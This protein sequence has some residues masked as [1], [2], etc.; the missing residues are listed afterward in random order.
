[1]GFAQQIVGEANMDTTPHFEIGSYRP[2]YLWGGPGTVRMNRLK[3][4]GV[5]VDEP[6]HDEAHSPTGARRVLDEM[7]CNWVHLMYDWGFP[8]EVEA[9]DWAA[10]ARGAKAYHEG[11]S[12]VFAYIQS[13]NCVYDGSF[14]DRDWY[15]ADANGKKTTY[16]AYSGRYMACLAHP[17]WRQ[18]L[19]DLAKGAIE[20]GAD[21]IFLDNLFQG[22]QPL[23][24]LDTWLGTTGCHCALC[25]QAYREETGGAIPASIRP[26]D[27]EFVR[28]L[29][30]RA[31][32][33][34]QLVGEI[35]AYA[36]ELQPGTPLAANDFDPIVR[37]SY[38]LY[39]IDLEALA[40]V[41][42][43][44]M[45]ENFAL[46]DW[47]AEPRPRLANNALNVRT[48][49]AIIGDSAHLSVLSYDVGIGFDPVYPP[50]RY[51]QG[52]AEATA[53]GVTM[54]TKG[55][56]YHD[57]EQM[58]LLT[59][60][61][62]APVRAAIGAYHAWLKANRT[63]LTGGRCN[64]APVALLY[65]GEALWLD[66]H[67][68]APLYFGAG[69]ALTAEGIPWRVI[70]PGDSLAGVRVVLVFDEQGQA[71]TSEGL[72]WRMF[73]RDTVQNGVQVFLAFEEE[74]QKLPPAEV[75]VVF[76]PELA[77]WQPRRPSAIGQRAILRS[78]VTA[79]TH[80]GL[81]AYGSLKPARLAM[82]SLGLPKL[83]T[84]TPLYYVPAAEARR[85]LVDALPPNLYPRLESESPAL[86]EVWRDGDTL[87]VHLAN[88]AREP[89][90]VRV[91][92]GAPLSGRA[93][94]PDGED[95][96]RCEGAE[97]A[98]ALD[99]YT[100]LLLTDASRIS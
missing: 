80:L 5:A 33:V 98:V 61:V 42:D 35:A 86:I 63:L 20:R 97:I 2:I 46:P 17:A 1:V 24:L 22:Q 44:T 78:A 74:G 48:A 94:T 76:V 58:T 68:L 14:R 32:Q 83:I 88:Y 43:V 30:W 15:A 87:Q 31:G 40:G 82:D 6:V 38:L 67:R 8:P 72:L 52:I 36:R 34:T 45:I 28:Y 81:K 47:S 77:G 23:S 91:R 71:L 100:I 9:E 79:L 89:Q 93:V 4:M 95:E 84:Q 99:I 69:Q 49:R 50:R 25:Q 13:S 19:R 12:P 62:Y 3:F 37:N 70:R 26:D 66:W 75:P 90:T 51:Q 64:A 60:E 18:H 96:S 21:G 59:A 16:F 53:C 92:L 39:G 56:E 65:P 73:R 29:R 7:G 41:Q 54:T 27:P 55:T 11:G 10:F 85:A 57:G